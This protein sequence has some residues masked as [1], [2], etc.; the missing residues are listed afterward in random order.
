MKLLLSLFVVVAVSVLSSLAYSAEKKV[1][2]ISDIDDTLKVSHVL[3]P[4]YAASRIPNYTVRF[5]GM[6]ELYQ[7]LAIEPNTE[8]RFAYVSNAPE[9]VA[10]LHVL[11]NSH[12]SFLQHNNFPAGVL[13]LRKNFFDKNHKIE[14]IRKQVDL[15]NPDIILF[16]GDNGQSDSAIY[17]EAVEEYKQKNIQMITFI[18]QVYKTE[19]SFLDVSVIPEI[20]NKLL[21]KQIG[22]VTPIEIALELNKK[23]LLSERSKAWMID[24]VA[25]NIANEKFYDLDSLN[26]I[27]FPSFQNCSEFVWRWPM[28]KELVPLVKKINSVCHKFF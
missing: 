5:T 15:E 11:L 14:E 7:L 10:G 12:L 25:P 16:F 21:A 22:F 1:L 3:N 23:G 13:S 20:G 27:T 9:S 8:T 19:K 4:I 26:D 28:T 18:H 24:N 6:S 17:Q 2:V